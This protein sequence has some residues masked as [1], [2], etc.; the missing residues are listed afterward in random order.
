MEWES[1]EWIIAVI[2]ID[3]LLPSTSL[4][5]RTTPGPFAVHAVANV[6]R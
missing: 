5:S 1:L 6:G 4:E 2:V 3:N